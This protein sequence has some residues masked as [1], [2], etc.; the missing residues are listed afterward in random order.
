VPVDEGE[1][2]EAPPSKSVIPQM[3]ILD[4]AP[5][6]F[7]QRR[8]ILRPAAGERAGESRVVDGGF[9][10]Y[11]DLNVVNA[12]NDPGRFTAIRRGCRSSTTTKSSGG[13]SSA[14][15][16]TSAIPE[17]RE[18]DRDGIA[19]RRREVRP[20]HCKPKLVRRPAQTRSGSPPPTCAQMWPASPRRQ[21][22]CETLLDSQRDRRHRGMWD[23]IGSRQPDAVPP[24]SGVGTP[25][26]RLRSCGMVDIQTGSRDT[27]S[28]MSAISGRRRSGS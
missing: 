21:P 28:Q 3:F 16:R 8:R 10:M 7:A 14:G 18:A 25:S 9:A 13:S 24:P 12:T 1:I 6:E 19:G 15:R 26:G 11:D 4:E 27:I 5:A 17:P 22:G 23:I 2:A 20:A